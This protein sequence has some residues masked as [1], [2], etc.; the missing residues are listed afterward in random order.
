MAV[1]QKHIDMAREVR[2]WIGQILV[3]LAGVI[4]II[5]ESRAKVVDTYNK[6]VD[7]VKSK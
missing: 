3:P 6:A 2:L 5:P 4:M 1:K 7:K